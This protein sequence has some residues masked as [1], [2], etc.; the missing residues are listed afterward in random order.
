MSQFLDR[1]ACEQLEQHSTVLSAIV[2]SQVRHFS[3]DPLL[4]HDD[5]KSEGMMIALHAL[6]RLRVEPGRSDSLLERY[7]TVAI[8]RNIAGRLKAISKKRGLMESL[9]SLGEIEEQLVRDNHNRNEVR[10]EE[11]MEWRRHAV[12]FWEKLS[13]RDCGILFLS[14]CPPPDLVVLNRNLMIRHY[15]RVS[16]RSLSLYTDLSADRVRSA[17]ANIRKVARGILR[18][19]RT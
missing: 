10:G 12:D 15:R 7:V 16:V 14:I 17:L 19:R 18:G 4:G 3:P 11:F 1:K 13:P 9:D 6:R 5:M 2:R 8:R